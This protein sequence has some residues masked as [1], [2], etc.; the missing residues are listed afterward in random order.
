MKHCNSRSRFKSPGLA[1]AVAFV[2]AIPASGKVLGEECREDGSQLI[3]TDCAGEALCTFCETHNERERV[4]RRALS[5]VV[6]ERIVTRMSWS[7]ALGDSQGA[8]Y[9][10][11]R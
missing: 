9:C 8:G 4:K 5:A 2:T 7:L 6:S 11:R 1:A 10:K 3:S